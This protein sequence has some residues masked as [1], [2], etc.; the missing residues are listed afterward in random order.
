MDLVM[1]RLSPVTGIFD[2]GI[3]SECSI[4]KDPTNPSPSC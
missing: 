3:F 1:P 2:Y 4:T